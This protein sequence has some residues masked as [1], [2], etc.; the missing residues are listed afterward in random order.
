MPTAARCFS[1]KWATCRWPRRSSCCGCWRAARSPGSARTRR[2]SVNVRIISATNRNLEDQIAAGTFRSDLYH[3]LKVVTINL[4]RLAERSQDIPLLIEHFIKQFSKRHH[5]H[6]QEHVDGGPAAAAG[7]RLA[8]QRAATAQRDR[9]HGR[10]RLRRRAGPRR[11]ARA[12]WP[13]RR[14]AADGRRRRQT[15]QAWSAS[16]WR[17]SSG[18]SSPKRCKQTGG[19]RECAAEMLG[20][21]QRTL[22]RKI[23]EYQSLAAEL[24]GSDQRARADDASTEPTIGQRKRLRMSGGRHRS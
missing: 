7:L 1:T 17:R 2:S 3:R 11:P 6:D 23:K 9:E 22:Y 8:G 12:S 21:G 15:W 10:G 16:R 14:T 13:A 18:C 20:I 19:N 4:P 24:A 5:K